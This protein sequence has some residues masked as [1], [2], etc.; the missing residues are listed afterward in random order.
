MISVSRRNQIT[1]H[2][3][4]VWDDLPYQRRYAQIPAS[5][6]PLIKLLPNHVA[7]VVGALGLAHHLTDTGLINGG[8]AKKEDFAPRPNPIP[9]AFNS[10]RA[11]AQTVHEES[12][13]TQLIEDI[14]LLVEAE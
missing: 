11:R 10:F 8:Y 14:R 6:P 7:A 3:Q 13:V 5:H 2:I 9:A 12:E 4:R 1:K